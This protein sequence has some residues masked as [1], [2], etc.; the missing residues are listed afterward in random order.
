MIKLKYHKI[1]E[2]AMKEMGKKQVSQK[3]F[4]SVLGIVVMFSLLVYFGTTGLAG[5][6]TTG[7][8]DEILEVIYTPGCGVDPAI[9]ARDVF[10][11]AVASTVTQNGCG[12]D[13]CYRVFTDGLAL[14]G[15]GGSTYIALGCKDP[16]VI[17]TMLA[18]CRQM[19]ATAC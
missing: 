19:L 1:T 11:E 10:K 16:Q 17:S 15:E 13:W 12:K 5:K 2:K 4:F 8:E 6:A 7:L 9:V 18:T 14:P 3:A